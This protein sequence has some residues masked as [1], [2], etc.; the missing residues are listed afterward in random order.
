M[1]SVPIAY[2]TS[3]RSFHFKKLLIAEE[4]NHAQKELRILSH[5]Q[6]VLLDSFQQIES[7]QKVGDQS[8][9]KETDQ[10][11]IRSSSVTRFT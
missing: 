8:R 7:S 6:R 2:L 3:K 10:A 9:N 4:L 1:P 11:E 5:V